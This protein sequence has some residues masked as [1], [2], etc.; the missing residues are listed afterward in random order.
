LTEE[1]EIRI[2]S[3]ELLWGGSYETEKSDRR[4]HYEEPAL[5]C[6]SYDGGKPSAAV[7]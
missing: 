2:I 5:F 7:L 1:Q 4:K 6:V 3:E